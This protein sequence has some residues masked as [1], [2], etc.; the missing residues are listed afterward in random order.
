MATDKSK[1]PTLFQNA[2]SEEKTVGGWESLK[3]S[4]YAF[5]EKIGGSGSLAKRFIVVPFSVLDTGQARWREKQTKWLPVF[6][7]LLCEIVY[8]WH[9]PKGGGNVLD[10]FGDPTRGIMAGCL[11]YQYT[12]IEPN[13]KQIEANERHAQMAK[14]KY[15]QMRMPQW[16]CADPISLD[17]HLP[18]GQQYDLIFTNLPIYSCA[19]LTDGFRARYKKIF[20]HAIAHLKQERFVVV[21]A[22]SILGEEFIEFSVEEVSKLIPNLGVHYYNRF[23]LAMS[24][25]VHGALKCFYKGES[26]GRIPEELGELD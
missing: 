5:A 26:A 21:M 13:R 16:L 24:G 22:R 9:M 10:P 6:D 12:G 14:L 19:D 18:R 7:P 15:P 25:N 1:L 8:L 4:S 11:G 3:A 20:A 23:E 17:Q 2:F